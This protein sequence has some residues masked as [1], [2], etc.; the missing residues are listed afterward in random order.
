MKEKLL[1]ILV[2]PDCKNNF[3]LTVF[4]RKDEEVIDGL[5]NCQCGNYFP[6]IN[7]IPRILSSALAEND[8]WLK[9]Y[10]HFIKDD[11][12]LSDFFYRLNQ[13]KEKIDKS[14]QKSFGFQW[15][16]FTKMENLFKESFLNYIYPVSED[17]FKGKFGLDAGCGC[18]RHI[19]YAAKFGA[20]MVGLDFSKAIETT[21]ANTAGLKNIHLVQADIF[22]PP[23][24]EGVFDFVYC[25]GVLHHLPDPNKGFGRLLG[26]V[27]PKHA[28]FIWVYSKTRKITNF[29]LNQIRKI[30]SKIPP[31][32]LYYLTF[33]CALFD[34][35][36]FII[37]YKLFK[38]I[39]FLRKFIEKIT[40]ERIKIYSEY[41]FH[42]THTDWFDRLSA[43]IRFYY[44]EKDMREWFAAYALKNIKISPTG[45]YGWR[46]YGEKIAANK[47]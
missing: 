44:D 37:P 12:K 6:I 34:W 28:I 14:T 41:S 29:F 3:K 17:F 7:G 33:I 40:F 4:F 22:N 8:N 25:I 32:L 42:V 18:G 31:K 10:S 36:F 16:K 1:D 30:T 24:K 35:F 5:L 26:L 21:Q 11:V 13:G 20:E 39:P 38:K 15:T 9:N 27:K 47:S 43:P 23:F 19:Y 2:C 46:G 45:K